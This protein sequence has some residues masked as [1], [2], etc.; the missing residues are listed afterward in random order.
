M[1]TEKRNRLIQGLSSDSGIYEIFTLDGKP[2]S[3]ID[4]YN[5]AGEMGL[6]HCVF[7]HDYNGNG[8]KNIRTLTFRSDSAFLTY[9]DIYQKPV[10]QNEFFLSKVNLRQEKI[11]HYVRFYGKAF[12]EGPDPYLIIGLDGSYAIEPRAIFALNPSCDNH[13]DVGCGQQ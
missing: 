11:D 8:T 6:N 12:L 3:V 4:Q 7:T 10:V 5:I 1:G 13:R 9:F 2:G